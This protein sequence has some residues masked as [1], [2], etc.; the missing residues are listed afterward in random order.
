MSDLETIAGAKFYIGGVLESKIVDFI[1]SDF[2]AQPWLTVDGWE[3]L[4]AYGD[5]SETIA[6]N[7][8]NRGRVTK[9]K[10]TF[11]AGDMSNTFATVPGNTGQAALKL[12]AKSKSN[13]AFK[14]QYDDAPSGGTP[15]QDLFIGLVMS[16]PFA[17]GGANDVKKVDVAI[18]INSNIVEVAAAP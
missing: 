2:D 18:G 16:A 12:A 8:I 9:Q 11:D 7:L 4:G 6:T 13:Y 5:S 14:I 15:S 17:G 10:G 1:A 3:S